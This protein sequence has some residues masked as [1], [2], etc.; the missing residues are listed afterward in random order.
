MI[1]RISLKY[2][3]VLIKKSIL[4]YLKNAGRWSAKMALANSK[5]GKRMR[6]PTEYMRFA[7]HLQH[8]EN[9]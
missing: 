7:K 3:I 2:G 8:N 4:F 9:K 6:Y 1:H 5:R